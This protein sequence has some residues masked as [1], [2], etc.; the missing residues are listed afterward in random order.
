[1]SLNPDTIANISFDLH[2]SPSSKVTTYRAAHTLGVTGHP[3]CYH[4]IVHVI[5]MIS[6]TDS[7]L[8]QPATQTG[9]AERSECSERSERSDRSS[10]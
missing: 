9:E 2:D 6:Q 4:N 10:T 8:P 3:T 7:F 5:M 1:M